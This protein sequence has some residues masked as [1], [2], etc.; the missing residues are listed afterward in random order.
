M[1]SWAPEL[2]GAVVIFCAR[3]IELTQHPFERG[4]CPGILGLG[5]RI[6]LGPSCR[7]V[8]KL[9]RCTETGEERDLCTANGPHLPSRHG[10]PLTQFGPF[11]TRP[12]PGSIPVRVDGRAYRSIWLDPD[13]WSVRIIDQS[14]LPHRFEIVRLT[15]VADAADAIAGMQVRG[16]PLIG[17]TAAYG[18]ALG[19]RE[20]PDDGGL[21]DAVARLRATRPTAVNLQWALERVGGTVRHLPPEERVQAAYREAVLIADED[22]EQNRAIGEHGL[23]LIREAAQRRDGAPVRVLTHCN[24]GWLA[25]VDVGTATAPLY[26]AHREGIPLHVWV[27][28]TRPRNQGGAL[29]AWELGHE[30]IP[31][32]VIVDNAGGHVMQR[33]EVD[34]CIVGTDRTTGAGDVANKIG[35]YLKA[36]AAHDLGIPFYV[37]SPSSSIDWTLDSGDDIPIEER[38]AREVSHLSGATESGDLATVQVTAPGSPVGNPAFDVTPAR[39]ITGLITERGVAPSTRAGLARLFPD[40]ADPSSEGSVAPSPVSVPG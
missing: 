36:L 2:G 11:Q 9:L 28:E 27:G 13:G 4:L 21:D 20:R 32:T 40:L 19:L 3:Q 6:G 34:L 37:A 31:H 29:T 10:E 33:G 22:V 17:A 26:L 25:T 15:S 8:R 23:A 30:G 12:I 38:A 24:A 39:L 35:T 14:R 5:H 18:L 7:G 1:A 16:A